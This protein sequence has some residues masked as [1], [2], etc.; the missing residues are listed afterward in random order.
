[1]SKYILLSLGMLWLM[2]KACFA[3]VDIQ[4]L[5]DC[6]ARYVYQF[7]QEKCSFN[8]NN[9]NSRP[10]GPMESFAT[11]ANAAA[12]ANKSALKYQMLRDADQACKQ[13]N[14]NACSDLKM[15]LFS[16]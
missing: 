11:G 12:D 9:G 8:N 15:M 4:C 6:T 13:G 2:S 10:P 16:K 3:D 5:S 7:C 1:M 14:Q